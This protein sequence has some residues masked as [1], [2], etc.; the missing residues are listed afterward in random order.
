MESFK[1]NEGKLIWLNIL[2][3]KKLK[4][5]LINIYALNKDNLDFFKKV[6]NIIESHKMDFVLLAGDLNITLN[7]HL[8]SHNYRQLN[9]PGARNEM[10]SIINKYNQHDMFRLNHQD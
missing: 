5:N 6:G 3:S 8:D 1:D 2:I 7:P 10:L 9:N 4:L